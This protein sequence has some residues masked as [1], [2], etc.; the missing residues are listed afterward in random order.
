MAF[1]KPKAG[2]HHSARQVRLGY[3]AGL[4]KRSRKKACINCGGRIFMRVCVACNDQNAPLKWRALYAREVRAATLV[5]A[6]GMLCNFCRGGG[7]VEYDPI[8][9]SV[10]HPGH[11]A[12]YRCHAEKIVGAMMETWA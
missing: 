9:R 12:A 4:S 8:A 2:I 7:E 10:C 11:L 3:K 1:G 5:E 6:A